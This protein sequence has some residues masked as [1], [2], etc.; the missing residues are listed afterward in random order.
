MLHTV[1]AGNKSHIQWSMDICNH[2]IAHGLAGDIFPESAEGAT[3]KFPHETNWRNQISALKGHLRVCRGILQKG[4][5][6]LRASL[7]PILVAER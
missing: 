7:P 6:T 5:Q 2:W 3:T 4:K 1:A